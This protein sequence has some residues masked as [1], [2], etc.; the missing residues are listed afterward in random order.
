[1][2]F[3]V[4]IIVANFVKLNCDRSYTTTMSEFELD[5]RPHVTLNNLLKF[6]GWSQSGGEAKLFIDQGLV[7]VDGNVEL[8][9]RCKVLAGQTVSMGEN[10]IL[11]VE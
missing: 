7:K 10:T 8:R 11:I 9:R 1:M 3:D 2:R 4:P 6:E 5:G